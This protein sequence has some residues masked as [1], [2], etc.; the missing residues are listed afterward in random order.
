MFLIKFLVPK[1]LAHF[2][3]VSAHHYITLFFILKK[4]Y[5]DLKQFF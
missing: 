1:V 4:T 2:L 3:N 5:L